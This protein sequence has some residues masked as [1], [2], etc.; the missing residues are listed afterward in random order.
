ME[1]LKLAAQKEKK[2][3]SEYHSYSDKEVDQPFLNVDT[4]L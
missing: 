2:R 1:L 4:V 3:L